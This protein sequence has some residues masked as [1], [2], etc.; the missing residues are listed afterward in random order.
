MRNIHFATNVQQCL[1]ECLAQASISDGF[2]CVL[3]S[4]HSDCLCSPSSL[5][6]VEITL[7]HGKYLR[8]LYW[9]VSW[10]IFCLKVEENIAAALELA[11]VGMDEEALSEITEILKP[12]KNQ[13][14]PSGI[15]QRWFFWQ[16][17]E[18]WNKVLWSPFFACLFSLG[19]LIL[20]VVQVE[21]VCCILWAFTCQNWK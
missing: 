9:L 14:W 16:F 3:L 1:S 11:T 6:V 20:I 5:T 17:Y 2:M 10:Y 12:V 18:L 8:N 4:V 13:T 15:Q 19:H 21:I 7:C